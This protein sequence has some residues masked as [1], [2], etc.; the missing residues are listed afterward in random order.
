VALR[1]LGVDIKGGRA[2]FGLLEAGDD[3][4]MWVPLEPRYVEL[5]DLFDTDEVRQVAT[6]VGA[7]LS[8]HNVDALA[9]RKRATKGKFAGGA[10]S[11]RMGA[12][13]QMASAPRQVTFITSQAAKK[14]A[15]DRALPSEVLAYQRDAWLCALVGMNG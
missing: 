15:K 6:Q 11:F 10:A 12:I 2:N 1:I 14:A 7:L 13:L 8:E 5:A 3:G 4:E 9:I